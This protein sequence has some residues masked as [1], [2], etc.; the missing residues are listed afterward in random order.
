M[1]CNITFK[2]NWILFLISSVLV[3]LLI[4]LPFGF[5]LSGL[6]E[7]WDTL[8]LF[9][10]NGLFFWAGSD[11]P[12][13]AHRLRPLTIFPHAL[14][15]FLDS[16]SFTFWHLFQMLALA[17]KGIAASMIAWFLTRS[18]GW[19]M[20]LG[21]LVILYPADTMQLSFRSIHINT[22]LALV[23]FA[24]AILVTAYDQ[25]RRVIRFWLALGSAIS[26]GVAILM[27]EAAIF[28]APMPFLILFAR[29]GV[30]RTLGYIRTYPLLSFS[31][32]VT[33]CVC[34]I[35]AMF[36]FSS[37]DSYQAGVVGGEAGLVTTL[38]HKLPK[39]FSIGLLR[40]LVG[41]WFDAAEMVLQ[42]YRNYSYLVFAMIVCI[43]LIYFRHRFFSTSNIDGVEGKVRGRHIPLR[44]ASIGLFLSILG[45]LPYL[46]SNAH[47]MIS[48][49]TYLFATP[50]AAMVFFACLMLLARIREWIA[51]I[52]GV[53]LL[54]LGMGAQLYQFHHYQQISDTQRLLL[55]SIV[56]N[57]DGNLGGKTLLILDGSEQLNNTWMLSVPSGLTPNVI[58]NALSYFYD[59]P[60]NSVEV[61]LMPDKTWQRADSLARSGSCV[62]GLDR[63]TF[64]AARPVTGPDLAPTPISP[65]FVMAKDKIVV[66]IINPDGSI[67][68]DSALNGYRVQLKSSMGHAAQRY[69]NI[70]AS[71]PWP[72]DFK[73]FIVYED[74]NNY[75][76]DFGKWWS[77]EL[78][79]HGDGWREAEWEINYFNHRA[80]AWKSQERSSLLFNFSPTNKPYVLQGKFDLIVSEPIQKSIR[81]ILNG[82]GVDYRWVDYGKFEADIP[83][84]ILVHGQNKIEFNS[85]TDPRYYGLSARLDWFEVRQRKQ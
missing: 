28:L 82:H 83:Y 45:Y 51:K 24:S 6:I 67:A 84:G 27:Y 17:L 76:W 18:R 64:K 73:Q 21:M 10:K 54:L 78:P 61:C 32:G 30:K 68:K 59:K 79:I 37:G 36:V 16:D 50:G 75:R 62:E 23:L 20:F 80:S 1:K 57:F 8:A 42:E 66:L 31:W 60:I 26:L 77:M 4:W 47:L 7:E 53:F 69:R 71:K 70:L 40:A 29:E 5:Q 72:L 81:I 13:A 43:V 41:G 44:I 85:A 12:L 34:I 46:S 58:G 49:R 14:S 56:E 39:L 9:T 48:Q 19:A 63:W 22:S 15:Y 55:R 3:V 65:D 35:H 11:S 38:S 52:A 25:P 2:R 33:A 74:Q